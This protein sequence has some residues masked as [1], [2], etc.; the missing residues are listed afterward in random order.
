MSRLQSKIDE[1]LA[2]VHAGRP[3]DAMSQ[4]QRL[5]QQSPRDV[6]VLSAML[7]ACRAANDFGKAEFYARQLVSLM[8]QHTDAHANL[9][10]VLAQLGER[11]RADA[12]AAYRKSL[13]LSPANDNARVGLAN[14]LLESGKPAEAIAVC[15]SAAL[16]RVQP[17]GAHAPPHAQLTISHASALMAMVRSDEALKLLNNAAVFYPSEPQLFILRCVAMHSS[18]EPQPDDIAKAHADTGRAIAATLPAVPALGHRVSATRP[19]KIG[20]LSPDLR[21][22][23]VAFFAQPLFEHLDRDHFELH[24]FHNSPQSTEDAFS[25]ILKPCF[26]SWTNVA[27]QPDDVLL[28]TLRSKELDVLIDL[29]G[30]AGHHRLR[31]LAAR[32]APVQMT[33]CGYPDTTGVPNID[34]RIVDSLTDPRSD[35]DLGRALHAQGQPDFDQRCSERLLRIDPCFLCYKPPT[36]APAPSLQ[37]DLGTHG[38]IRFASFNTVR[39]LNPFCVELWSRVLREVPGSRLLLKSRELQDPAMVESLRAMFSKHTIADRVDFLQPTKSIAEHLSLY[40]R[41]HIALDTFPYHGTTTTCEAL[42]MG[43]PVVTLA[44]DRH[45][46]RVGVSL[47]TNATRTVSDNGTSHSNSCTLSDLISHSPDQFVSTAAA[48]AQDHARVAS[49][50]SSL[51]ATMHASVLCGAKAFANRFGQ[52]IL[53][54]CKQSSQTRD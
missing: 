47:L 12:V 43:V 16:Q 7:Y 17:G 15:E 42:W 14:L 30:L 5:F 3:A 41:V 49:L 45:A 4:L 22:H 19:L 11:K 13:E 53:E 46:S 39:K 23:S 25:Q 28:A 35:S 40:S 36:D 21:T 50:R 31:L 1:S 51:R 9:G 8:P 29:T 2:L 18:A 10:I 33:Y 32:A 20:I 26:K 24:A 37:P 38:G 34:F 6:G 27:S 52:A 54:A 48:L 44:G